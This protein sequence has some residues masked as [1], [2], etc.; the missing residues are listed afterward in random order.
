MTTSFKMNTGTSRGLVVSIEPSSRRPFFCQ[1]YHSGMLVNPDSK[2]I[3]ILSVP[4]NSWG[5]KTRARRAR[6]S[7]QVG[8]NSVEMVKESLSYKKA[9]VDIDAGSEL[10]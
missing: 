4:A 6:F 9:G 3:H 2:K 10:V 8:V 7:K 1:L 5:G